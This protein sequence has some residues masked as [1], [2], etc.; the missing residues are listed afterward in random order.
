MPRNFLCDKLVYR[1]F[2]AGE[3]GSQG[4]SVGFGVEW[5]GGVGSA[6]GLI[7]GKWDCDDDVGGFR[8]STTEMTLG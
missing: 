3:L 6:C 5:G 4:R 2:W 7:G 8:A 1:R